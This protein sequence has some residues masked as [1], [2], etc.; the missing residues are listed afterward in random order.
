MK[1]LRLNTEGFLVVPLGVTISLV[2][3]GSNQSQG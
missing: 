1:A 2:G 3:D